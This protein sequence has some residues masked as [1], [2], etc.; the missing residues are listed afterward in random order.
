MPT[1]PVLPPVQQTTEVDLLHRTILHVHLE[2]G[3]GPQLVGIERRSSGLRL[4]FL[5]LAADDPLADLAGF[6]AP[7]EWWAVGVTGPAGVLDANAGGPDRDRTGRH[8]PPTAFVHVVTRAGHAASAL[9]HPTPS[10][11]GRR[12]SSITARAGLVDD[13]LRRVLGLPT[14]PAPPTTIDFWTAVWLDRLLA[15]AAAGRLDGCSWHD[16]CL[17][18]PIVGFAAQA[19]ADQLECHRVAAD[20]ETAVAVLARTWTWRT[21]RESARTGRDILGTVGAALAGWMDDGIYARVHLSRVPAV[22][23]SLPSLAE[24]LPAATAHRLRGTCRTWGAHP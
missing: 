22:A 6:V 21:L 8:P 12:S 4:G 18:H 23:E 11:P 10:A 3:G 9:L 1:S 15:T 19:G 17:L 14:P 16:L 24:L 20:L 5:P 7:P 13:H 2:S